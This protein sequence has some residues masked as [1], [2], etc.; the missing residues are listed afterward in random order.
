M[1]LSG[2]TRK[3]SKHRILPEGIAASPQGFLFLGWHPLE[4]LVSAYLPLHSKGH[5]TELGTESVPGT[6][7]MNG[8]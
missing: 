7:F 3:F 1:G 8:D 2:K 4:D 6:G 5:S